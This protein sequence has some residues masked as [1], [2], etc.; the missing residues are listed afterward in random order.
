[1]GARFIDQQRHHKGAVTAC[2]DF[3]Q[4]PV[5]RLS[6]VIASSLQG[7]EAAVSSIR[8]QYCSGHFSL[9]VGVDCQHAVVPSYYS[10]RA[11]QYSTAMHLLSRC[12]TDAR[13]YSLDSWCGAAEIMFCNAVVSALVRKTGLLQCRVHLVV[14]IQ[15]GCGDHDRARRLINSSAGSVTCCNLSM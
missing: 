1:M 5:R 10:C 14:I 12:Y 13:E 7:V 4:G 3:H 11:V 9:S 6:T 15:L 2:G 8:V